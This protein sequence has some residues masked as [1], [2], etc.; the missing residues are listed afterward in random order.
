MNNEKTESQKD[1]Q[2]ETSIQQ[3]VS[4]EMSAR[5]FEPKTME[6]A[7]RFAQALSGSELVPATYKGKPGDCLIALDLAM[8]LD[9]PWLAIMQHVYTVKG[10]PAMDS[11]LCTALV[12]RSGI[13]LDPLEYEV[14]GN[15]ASDV[16]Y[17]VRAYATRKKTGKTLY[18]P[19]IDWALVKG[20]GWLARDGSKWKTMPEQMF[21]YRAASW[22]Q[23]RFCPELTMG[24]VSVD[25]AYDIPEVKQVESFAETLEASNEKI[26]NEAGSENVEIAQ[27]E[28]NIPDIQAKVDDQK[29]KL[30]SGDN[31]RKKK[32]PAK[33]EGNYTCGNGHTF[34]EP[35][36]SGENNI[37][38]CPACFTANITENTVTAVVKPE[39][40]ED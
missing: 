1:V 18:G 37:P 8:R 15:N 2:S 32:E 11:A 27:S 25:E 36:F 28:E 22:F 12:N 7:W 5:G 26:E 4:V 6:Q 34:D 40:M 39:F 24:M 16:S 14:V 35:K 30:K 17:K 31:G 3:K 29:K 19:W 23:R 33:S 9:A 13:F 10:R 20:E 21:H 38:I